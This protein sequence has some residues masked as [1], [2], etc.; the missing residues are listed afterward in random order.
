MW[1]LLGAC[2]TRTDIVLSRYEEDTSWVQ[3]FATGAKLL[4]YNKGSALNGTIELPNVG[5]ESHTYLHHIVHNYEDLARWTVFSQARE[6]SFGYKGHLSRGVTFQDYLKEQVSTFWVNTAA[7]TKTGEW[8]F[9]QSLRA[10][11]T[12]GAH[13]DPTSL[14]DRMRCP[15]KEFGSCENMDGFN[16][17]LRNKCSTQGL[18]LED[19]WTGYL[20]E[21]SNLTTVYFPQGA[22]FAV[23]QD[24]IKQRP[25]SFY[26]RLMELLARDV[27]PCAGYLLEWTWPLVFRAL[28]CMSAGRRRR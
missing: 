23:S 19:Y 22:R 28:P 7:V 12:Q 20:E 8:T 27:D 6:P 10:S 1:G 5:R 21:A 18:E 25:L 26:R 13:A 11:F 24:K 4:I 17:F 2:M 14:S 15:E 3:P 16:D 9:C